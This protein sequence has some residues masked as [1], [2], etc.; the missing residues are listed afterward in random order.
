MSKAVNEELLFAHTNLMVLKNLSTMIADFFFTGDTCP[1]NDIEK[2]YGFIVSTLTVMNE[3]IDT[4]E[5]ALDVAIRVN[6]QE[7]GNTLESDRA[8]SD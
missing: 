7:M 2:N 3:R 8:N 4:M 5:S 1:G 6:L